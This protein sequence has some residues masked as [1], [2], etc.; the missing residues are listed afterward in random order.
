MAF[1][2]SP[3][4]RTKPAA[5]GKAWRK[6]RR[7]ANVGLEPTISECK[8]DF[9]PMKYRVSTLSV[10]TC[11]F[12]SSKQH[13]RTSEN[14][15]TSSIEHRLALLE[16]EVTVFFTNHTDLTI[17]SRRR[18]GTCD[19]GYLASTT[20][21]K[22]CGHGQVRTVSFARSI[23]NLSPI[24]S[25]W[26]FQTTQRTGGTIRDGYLRALP[27]SYCLFWRQIGFEPIT[28]SVWRK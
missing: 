26:R 13:G 4:T 8:S 16:Q 20:P 27:L 22:P 24:A 18:Y 10:T 17:S 12:V 3:L 11:R 23:R 15:V 6:N 21:Q 2:D 14:R 7:F 5:T 1:L 9:Q 28:S 19:F 25:T